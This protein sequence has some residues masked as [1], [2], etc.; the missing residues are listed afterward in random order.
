MIFLIQYD[1]GSGMLIENQQYP[2]SLLDEANADR[3]KAE[4]EHADNSEMEIV[5]LRSASLDELKRT[6]ARYFKSLTELQF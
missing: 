6:H 3:L 1:R 4:I 5:I 2:D